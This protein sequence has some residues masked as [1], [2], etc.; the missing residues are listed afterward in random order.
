MPGPSQKLKN[1]RM[2]GKQ[3]TRGFSL[4]NL[5]MIKVSVVSIILCTS[6][7]PPVDQPNLC[8]SRK[9]ALPLQIAPS[10]FFTT[11]KR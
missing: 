10:G 7:F 4:P 6:M 3:K 2:Y 9:P 5:C 8:V 1:S 11:L